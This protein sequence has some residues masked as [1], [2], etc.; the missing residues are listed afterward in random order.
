MPPTQR[1]LRLSLLFLTYWGRSVTSRSITSSLAFVPS[2]VSTIYHHSLSHFDK[3]EHQCLTVPT[4]QRSRPTTSL[5][6][7]PINRHFICNY[8]KDDPVTI[9]YETKRG[10]GK[11]SNKTVKKENFPSKICVVCNRPFIYRK[12]WADCWDEVTCCS[13]RCNSMR[14]GGKKSEA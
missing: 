4:I 8:H 6:Y 11:T 2:S 3:N 5:F 12:K 14:R 9:F 13:K 10:R 1:T 7:L